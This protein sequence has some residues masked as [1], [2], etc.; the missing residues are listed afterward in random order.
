MLLSPCLRRDSPRR[1]ACFWLSEGE[2]GYHEPDRA[3]DQHFEEPERKRVAHQ[4]T[5]QVSWAEQA[6]PTR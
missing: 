3:P 6:M 2:L 5:P 4:G 1:G